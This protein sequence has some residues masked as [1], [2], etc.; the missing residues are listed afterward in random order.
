MHVPPVRPT[1]ADAIATMIRCLD[2][3]RIDGIKTTVPFHKRVLS[4]T[5]FV[6]GLVD[7]GF[8]ERELLPAG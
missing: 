6:E 4:H 8:V 1:R 7:T 3:L 5:T 2:E